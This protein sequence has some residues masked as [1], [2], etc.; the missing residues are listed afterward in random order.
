MPCV[1]APS[2]LVISTVPAVSAVTAMATVTMRTVIVSRQPRKIV[3]PLPTPI[4]A[5]A[6]PKR[7][8]AVSWPFDRA[9]NVDELVGLLN[10]GRGM[11]RHCR[12]VTRQT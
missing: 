6:V 3:I 2:G 8:A 4:I 10:A 5:L 11:G 1:V 7:V 9:M 12:R